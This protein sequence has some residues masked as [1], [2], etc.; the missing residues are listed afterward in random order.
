MKHT[1]GKWMV[2]KS[3]KFRYEVISDK[4]HDS[5][6]GY[7]D[8][9]LICT[10]FY[11]ETSSDEEIEA[12]AKLIA[13]APELLEALQ[14][15]MNYRKIFEGFLLANKSEQADGISPFIKAEKAIKKATK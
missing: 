5:R 6:M 4:P 3:G 2:A 8:E 1:K 9:T 13:V 11:P 14:V 10:L 12:N 15:L 7:I